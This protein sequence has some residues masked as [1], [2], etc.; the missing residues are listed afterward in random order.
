[1]R[2][3]H[4]SSDVSHAV[5]NAKPCGEGLRALVQTLTTQV[6]RAWILIVKR[7]AAQT[8]TSCTRSL[9]AQSSCCNDIAQR[10]LKMLLKMQSL[11]VK[12]F[13]FCF[14]HRQHSR[15]RHKLLRLIEN[16][17]ALTLIGAG[18]SSANL[19]ECFRLTHLRLGFGGLCL[20]R[21]TSKHMSSDWRLL[22]VSEL[23]SK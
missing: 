14:R 19:R 4:S 18:S 2:H 3:L 23:V 6:L 12:V 13:K 5:E 22:L 7:D 9:A 17:F 15:F 10:M 8:R 20:C 16:M 1:M 21:H 11:P